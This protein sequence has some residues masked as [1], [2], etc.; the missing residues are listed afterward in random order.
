MKI[1]LAF[2]IGKG[3]T[4]DTLIRMKT[5]S[6]YSHVEMIIKD[7]WVSSSGLSGGVTIKDLRALDFEN[8]E[9]I[10]L[11]VNGRK[12]KKVLKFIED[13]KDAKYDYLGVF[14][15]GG[16]GINLEDKDKFY[17]SEIMVILLQLFEYEPVKNLTPSKIDPGELYNIIKD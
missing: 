17:C 14:F 16:F 12:L 11:E 2:Y 3:N 8:W 6:V 13:N 7:K 9:Y 10:E 15:G 4:V 1:T 5:K